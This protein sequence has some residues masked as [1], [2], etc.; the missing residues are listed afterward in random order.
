MIINV[1]WVIFVVISR[2]TQAP[3]LVRKPR[4]H[5]Y[6][7]SSDGDFNN[8]KHG[9]IQDEEPT[10]SDMP[11][12]VCVSITPAQFPSTCSGESNPMHIRQGYRSSRSPT[13]RIHATSTQLHQCR[14][15]RWG[16][17]SREVA[18]P[19]MLITTFLL[20][21]TVHLHTHTSFLY[22]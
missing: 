7:T 21:T 10:T 2:G 11:T 12:C 1:P 6:I 20:C 4:H 14:Q 15:D 3:S 22:P 18:L 16:M 19:T 9:V 8:F 13:E 17:T 5:Y